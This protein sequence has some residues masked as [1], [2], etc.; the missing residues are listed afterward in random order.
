MDIGEGIMIAMRRQKMRKHP[1]VIHGGE[2]SHRLVVHRKPVAP[3]N[4]HLAL[5]MRRVT[6]RCSW[7]HE[8]EANR[9]QFVMMLRSMEKGA[10]GRHYGLLQR[11]CP[12]DGSE[13][14][15]QATVSGVVF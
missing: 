5:P 1:G 14:R 2:L 8:T 11:G 7:P 3:G 10:V 12:G 4:G 6:N 13:T 9:F 15:D